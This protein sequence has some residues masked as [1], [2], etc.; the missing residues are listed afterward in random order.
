MLLRCRIASAL[1]CV[2]MAASLASA[3]T[4]TFMYLEGTSSA[5]DMTPDGRI[6]VGGHPTQGGYYW[7]AEDGFT[8]IGGNQAVAVSD[9]GSVIFGSVTNEDGHEEAAI[10]TADAGWELLGG[11]PGGLPCPS[12]S[13]AYEL[14]AD[15]SVA[16]GLSWI[17]GCDGAAFRWTPE[18]EMVGLETLANGGNRA[19]VVSADG[20]LA[21]GFAQGSFSRTPA[22]WYADGTGE[23]L[24]P[25]NGDVSGEVRG[26]NDD[27][28]ILLGNWDGD[29]FYWTEDEGV[30]TFEGVITSWVAA[31]LDIAD[32]GTIVGFDYMM[33]SRIGWIRPAGDNAYQLAQYLIARGAEGVPSQLQVAQA[34]S[35]DGRVIIGHNFPG[36]GWIAYLGSPADINGDGK[37]DVLDLLEV[38]GAWGECSG[39]C[40]ADVNGDGVVDVLDLLAVLSAWD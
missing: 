6:V 25:P 19:S 11:L 31:P 12:I 30:V 8:Y 37:V 13:S 28:T 17:D 4:A 7:T 20:Q 26:M 29:A 18:D 33:T 35:A 10:W 15:G 22:I 1:A 16:V 21:A 9:D 36:G 27:G 14:S 40:P 23:L 39:E 3:Q 2:F 24:D 38:L 34:I 32:N 5:M